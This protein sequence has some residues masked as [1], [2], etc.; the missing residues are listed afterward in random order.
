MP[1]ACWVLQPLHVLSQS[2]ARPGPR[3]HCRHAQMG[4]AAAEAVICAPGA[5][6]G[7]P[8]RAGGEGEKQVAAAQPG[9]GGC[10]RVRVVLMVVYQCVHLLSLPLILR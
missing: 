5:A 3:C 8:Q 10:K 4:T 6:A 2:G 1:A 9:M 7:L